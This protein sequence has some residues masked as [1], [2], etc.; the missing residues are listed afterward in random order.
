MPRTCGGVLR[1]AKTLGLVVLGLLMACGAGE[2]LVRL[3]TADQHNHLIEMWRYAALLQRHSADPRIGHEH[4]PGRTAQLEGVE[5]AI[6]RLGMR[7]PEPD[8]NAADKEN[9]V[10][11]G[12]SIA[13]GWGVP[14]A[15]TLRGRL[16]R[17]L[18]RDYQVMTTGVGNMNMTQIVARW[19]QDSPKIRTD[20]VVVLATMRA[21]EI[22]REK[23]ASWL[24]RHSQLYMLATAFAQMARQSRLNRDGLVQMYRRQWQDGAGRA[25]MATALDRLQRDR[26][27]R[28]Y[29]VV[30]VMVPE[31]HD[32][33]P[34]RFGFVTDVMRAEATRRGW[35]FVDPLPAL[36]VRP[37][38][39]Y[40]VAA[41]DVH[42]N[43]A[44]FGILAAELMP[45]LAQRN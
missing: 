5:I 10:I 35:S 24:M 26:N 11:I 22:V 28:G 42:P 30:V 32:F 14:E 27:A 44:A 12:D 13:M 40:W 25:E 33:A 17:E 15:Q 29:R 39:A 34:Y 21:P 1:A 2:A 7:G 8:L 16:A 3:A 18:G 23:H 19:L 45:Y 6:N 31:P 38:R 37:A 9:V 41:D 43:A 4:I 20:T 36:R